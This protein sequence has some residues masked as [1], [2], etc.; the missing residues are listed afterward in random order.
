MRALGLA[1]GVLER[2]TASLFGSSLIARCL[3]GGVDARHAPGMPSA[4]LPGEPPRPRPMRSSISLVAAVCALLIG[5]GGDKFQA[6][7]VLGGELVSV[8][9]L[10]RGH[11]TFGRFCASCHGYDG[12]AN[13]PAARRL[14]P[15]PRDFTL[16]QFKHKSTPGE[17]LP[18]DSDMANTVR[19]GVP[20]TGM[21][22]WPNLSRADLSAVLAYIKVF[23][24]RWRGDA[25]SKKTNDQSGVRHSASTV[26]PNPPLT[27]KRLTN[28]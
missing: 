21:P 10:N 9:T 2:R 15:R 1:I 14:E 7:L 3:A 26:L 8:E 23:S 12:K 5:C 6:P 28:E 11:Q 18:S 19:N 25:A 17:A 13:T 20:G 27:A 24:P 4:L 16:A 22:A